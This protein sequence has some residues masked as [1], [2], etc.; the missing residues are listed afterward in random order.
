MKHNNKTY[1]IDLE[2]NK[3]LSLVKDYLKDLG[4][5][6]K[7]EIKRY[8]NNGIVKYEVYNYIIYHGKETKVLSELDCSNYMELLKK[9][10][11]REDNEVFKIYPVIKN[12]RVS[13]NIAYSYSN[14][15]TYRK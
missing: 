3:S 11:E 2:E 1:I 14:Q 7:V 12:D 10:F 4:Y 6:E 15:K 5:S 8:L 9:V 13:F